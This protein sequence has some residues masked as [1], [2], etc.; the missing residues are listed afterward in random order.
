[1]TKM[2]ISNTQKHCCITC[3][4][5]FI[6]YHKSDLEILIVATVC[7]IIESNHW[8]ERYHKIKCSRL[9][10]LY[11]GETDHMRLIEI[12]FDWLNN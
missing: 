4:K 3:I 5:S 11:R 6:T 12:N 1:M 2:T 8:I 10:A 9:H 7:L